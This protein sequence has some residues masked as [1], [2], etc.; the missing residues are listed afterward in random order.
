MASREF[1]DSSGVVWRVWDVTPAHL[2]PITRSEEYMEPYAGGWLAFESRFEKRRLVAPYW[3]R[4]HEYDLKQLEALLD[5]ATPVPKKRKET[6]SG[7]R[8]ALLE[9]D[10]DELARA[11]HERTFRSPRGRQWIA[12]LHESATPAGETEIVLRLTSGDSVVDVKDWPK[13][14]KE[15]SRDEF[16]LLLLDAVP[17]RRATLGEEPQRRHDDRPDEEEIE[18]RA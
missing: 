11:E 15:L 16:A 14:W 18:T 1:T 3:G 13:D 10:A 7:E 17:P 5:A 12:R 9:H 6:P 4:W 8:L 2:H